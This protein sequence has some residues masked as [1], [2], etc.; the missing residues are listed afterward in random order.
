MNSRTFWP[1]VLIVAGILFLLDNLGVLPG[2]AWGWIWPL[3][4]V[5]VG[6]NLLLGRRP[7]APETAEGSLPLAGAT[8]ARLTV[9]HGAGRLEARAG[10]PAGML[11]AGTFGGG[12][13]QQAQRQGNELDVTL[14]AGD[15][16]WTDWLWPW[17]WGGPHTRRDW[18]LA[19][20]PEIPLRLSFD[21]G[22][23]ESRLDLSELRVTELR[24]NTGASST[25]VTLPA[26]AGHTRARITAGAAAVKVSVPGG[27]AARIRGHMGAG[28]L[29]IDP[30]RFP[31]RGNVYESDGFEAAANRVEL[32]VEGGAGEISV[33]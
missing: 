27:V 3:V 25:E 16:D 29:N 20:S 15:Q 26:Q 5:G 1:F 2:N 7:A 32:E 4:L 33:R 10:A 18:N 13:R 11:L 28:A 14:Q 24:I 8:S 6:L 12:L 23:S 22:A 30:A 19:L 17:N 21:T 9:R 31:R